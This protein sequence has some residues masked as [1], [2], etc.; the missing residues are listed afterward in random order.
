MRDFKA[1]FEEYNRSD[2]T[3][4][5]PA[6]DATFRKRVKWLARQLSSGVRVLEFG[7]GEGVVLAALS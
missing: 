6:F 2:P 3:V 1:Y 5:D 4:A 7:C